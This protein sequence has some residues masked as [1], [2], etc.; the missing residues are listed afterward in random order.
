MLL[1][2]HLSQTHPHDAPESARNRHRSPERF[3]VHG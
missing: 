2:S 3:L 1:S